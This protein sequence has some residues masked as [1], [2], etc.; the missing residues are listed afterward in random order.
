MSYRLSWHKNAVKFLEKCSPKQK[1]TV[2]Q[3]EAFEQHIEA[4]QKI[5][6]D[7]A[8]RKQAVLT[9]YL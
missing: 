7:A 3:I 1:E 8:S 6:T 4:A 2:S 9:H 5:I